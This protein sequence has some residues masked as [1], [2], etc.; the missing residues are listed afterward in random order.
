VTRDR[1]EAVLNALANQL[2]AEARQGENLAA[3]AFEARVRTVLGELL[4]REGVAAELNSRPQVFPDIVAEQFGIE[5]KFTDSDTWRSIANSVFEGTRDANVKHVYLLFGK[6]GGTPEVRWGR[7]G[8]CVMHVRTSHVPRFEVEIGTDQSLF[9]KFGISYEEFSVLS[10]PEK[11]RYIREYAR[12][13]HKKDGDRLWWLED[14][15]ESAQQHSLDLEVRLYMGLEQAEKRKL[16]AEAALLC[17]QIVKPSRA[18]KK[19][20]DAAMYLLT[21]HGV[22]CPQSRDL[23]TAG[24]VAEKTNRSRGRRD[25]IQRSLKDIESEMRRAAEYLEDALFVEYWGFTVP[26]K[27]RI[28]EWLQLADQ[29]ARGWKPS[30]VLFRS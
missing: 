8:D 18:K 16:R 28:K 14:K 15:P 11:M 17:P 13:R 4:E 23:F 5:V 30:K 9:A 7:Y 22:L 12:S 26:R 2:T 6:M 21:Y 29:Y 25:Y 24:S 10:I 1:F 19:Y 20:D 3:A 27:R